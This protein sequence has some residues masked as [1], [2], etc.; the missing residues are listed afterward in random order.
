MPI[1]V[2]K[3]T[4]V[5]CQG[6]TGNHPSSPVRRT[7]EGGAQRRMRA[8]EAGRIAGGSAHGAGVVLARAKPALIRPSGTFSLALRG[9][10]VNIANAS[11]RSETP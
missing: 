8:R 10:R 1:L 2:N 11:I 6:I 3:H 7:G 9:R 5:I 4:T